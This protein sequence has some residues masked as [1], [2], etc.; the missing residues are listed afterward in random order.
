MSGNQRLTMRPTERIGRSRLGTELLVQGYVSAQRE[1]LNR[2][3]ASGN[4]ASTWIRIAE[5]IDGINREQWRQLIGE[6]GTEGMRRLKERFAARL[7]QISRLFQ[8][9]SVTQASRDR[10]MVD[11]EGL[12]ADS[13]T[14]EDHVGRFDALYQRHVAIGWIGLRHAVEAAIGPAEIIRAFGIVFDADPGSRP[15]AVR[16]TNPP[17]RL[18]VPINAKIT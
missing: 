11:L 7:D 10:L 2:M 17:L 15:P 12:I 8:R 9:S 5:A 1:L 13:R 18:P 16:S 3:V 6:G 4:S 14:W